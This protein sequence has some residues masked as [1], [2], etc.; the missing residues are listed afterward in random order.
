[1]D[2]NIENLPNESTICIIMVKKRYNVRAFS[3]AELVD[4]V[5]PN[6]VTNSIVSREFNVWVCLLGNQVVQGDPNTRRI[7]IKAAEEDLIMLTDF[8]QDLLDSFKTYWNN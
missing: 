3:Y 1:M 7:C 8:G 4:C 6:N 5:E 2:L